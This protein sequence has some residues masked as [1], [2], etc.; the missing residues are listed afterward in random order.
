MSAFEG[1]KYWDVDLVLSEVLQFEVSSPQITGTVAQ[2][3][4]VKNDPDYK[5]EQN[6][7]VIG[8]GVR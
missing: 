7:P 1:V 2:V 5:M 6:D 4:P 3:L 8:D